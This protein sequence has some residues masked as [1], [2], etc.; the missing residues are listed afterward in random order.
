MPS[1]FDPRLRAMAEVIVRIGLNLQSGQPLLITDPYDLLGVHPEAMP[2]ATAVERAAGT[3]TSIATA[4]V[5]L[6][7]QLAEGDDL[8]G[9][10][11]L[12]R[13][14]VAQLQG[15]LNRGGAFLFLT[16]SA[17]QLHVGLSSGRLARFRA[18]KW[19][20]LGP[21]IQLL[22]R[23]ATQ[24]T[25][26]PA[27]TADWA[28]VAGTTVGD[29]WNT[30]GAALRLSAADP[31]AEWRLHLAGIGWQRDQLN[32]T[33]TRQVR[34]VGPGTD[35]IV[36]IPRLHRWCTAQLVTQRGVAYV[37]NLPAEEIFT[38]PHKGSATGR[39]R[40]RRPV[41][42]AGCVIEDIE[43]EFARGR[44]THARASAGQEALEHLLATDE[45]ACRL[46]EV[47]L[48]PGKNALP[49][50]GSAHHHILLDE[51][52]RHHVAL[53]DSYRFCA[54]AWWPFGLNSSLVHLDLPLEAEA[55]LT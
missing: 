9:Y 11:S 1:E 12:V 26:A 6:L 48:V 13:R 44:V 43:L 31:V 32:A 42:H 40:V 3:G 16:G 18:A 22:V 51:N 10:E 20:L 25:A 52:A 7:R 8:A 53:G 41:I 5:A 30:M 45:G 36:R 24:W 35:L 49:W 33:A 15:H 39:V 4:D 27:P 34:F 29:L 23:G 28:A 37:A 55:E 50:A 19:R 17:P 54:R 2:L 21:F 14:H 46:G 38:A 47:A